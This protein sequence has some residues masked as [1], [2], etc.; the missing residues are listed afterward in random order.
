MLVDSH[1]HL[2][3]EDIFNDINNVLD[4][5]N[6]L[7]VSKFIC[8]G[9]NL[10]DSI[11]SLNIAKEFKNVYASTGIH[12][13]D[14]NNLPEDYINQIYNLMSNPEMVAVGEIGLDYFKSTTQPSLQKTV[15]RAQME[16][17]KELKKPIIFH[18]READEDIISILKEFPDVKGVAHC[19]S[20]TLET[21]EKF[22]EMGYLI[23]FSGNL[24]F[25]NSH[26]PNVAKNISLNNILVETD[27]PFLSPVPHRG[28]P[29]E[30]GRTR[31]V[32]EKL[33]DI[34]NIDFKVVSKKTTQNAISL[35]NLN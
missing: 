31:F 24:T 32:A 6:S 13:H 25:K 28:K 4:R 2:Y 3:F 33:A 20:S 15:L 21:A 10:E 35:F 14:V 30:P 8:V 9:T 16:V 7:G 12:P 34:K 22:I 27:S 29:N 26:L 5:A 23:S 17:A 11:L 1:C 18:N 19:F